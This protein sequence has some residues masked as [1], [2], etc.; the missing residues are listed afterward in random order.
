MPI[1]LERPRGSRRWF[2]PPLIIGGIARIGTIVNLGEKQ[3][4]IELVGSAQAP[5]GQFSR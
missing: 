4:R 2:L 1:T 3:L 5:T